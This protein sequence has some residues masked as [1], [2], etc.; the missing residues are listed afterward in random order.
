MR[1]CVGG[2]GGGWGGGGVM[3]VWLFLSIQ[4]LLDSAHASCL[5]AQRSGSRHHILKGGCNATKNGALVVDVGANFGYYTLLAASMG[6]RV[7]AW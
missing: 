6:C 3:V 5:T 2:F 4:R 7:V 1:E